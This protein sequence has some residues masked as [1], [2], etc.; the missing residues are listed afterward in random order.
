MTPHPLSPPIV[1]ACHLG[2]HTT[3]ALA[4]EWSITDRSAYFRFNHARRC[5]WLKR[6][7]RGKGNGS[8]WWTVRVGKMVE[9]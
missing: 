3:S 7:H 4:R 1:W 6:T 8:C 9:G 5:G 2:C